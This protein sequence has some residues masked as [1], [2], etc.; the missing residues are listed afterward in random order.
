MYFSALILDDLIRFVINSGMDKSEAKT[1]FSSFEVEQGLISYEAMSKAFLKAYALT[2]DEL[3]GL[4][5]GEQIVLKVKEQVDAIMKSGKHL[6]EA[7]EDAVTYSRM[8][9]DALE[10]RINENQTTLTL[11][12]GVN[13]EWALQDAFATKQITDVTLVCANKSI[14]MITGKTHR[15]NSVQFNYPPPGNVKEYYRIFDCSIQF[16]HERPSIQFSSEIFNRT[17][18]HANP[19]LLNRLKNEADIQLEK[20]TRQTSLE[21]KVK[22]MILEQLPERC[23]MEEAAKAV[24]MS[25]RTFQRELQRLGTGFKEIEKNVLLKM[26]KNLLNQDTSLAEASYLLGFSEL[27]AFIRF[28]KLGADTTPGKFKRKLQSAN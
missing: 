8:I 13:P 18:T 20:I 21:D 22:R 6:K 11:S 12:F 24:N 7:F 19:S 23:S 25:T 1:A 9:S 26:A 10:G 2:G 17:S 14:Y 3:I 27:S 5:L 4:H 15:P 28:F 16:N